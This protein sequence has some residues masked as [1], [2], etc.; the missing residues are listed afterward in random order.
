MKKT[1]IDAGPLIAL[2]DRNDYYHKK[3]IEFIKKYNGKLITTWPVVTEVL[4]VLDFNINIQL[5]FLQ[6]IERDGLEVLPTNKEQI[7]RILE[8]SRKYS[9]VPMDLA[10]ATLIVLSEEL[11]IKDIIT[12]D[13]DFYVYRNIRNEYLNNLLIL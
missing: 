8:L 5:D 13:S 6:W 4:H 10:D 7:K 2:F 1:L 9:N 11:Q 12:I 3:S